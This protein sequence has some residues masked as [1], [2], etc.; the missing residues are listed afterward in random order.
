MSEFNTNR[1]TYEASCEIAASKGLLVVLPKPNEL[2]IDIDSDSAFATFEV[3]VERVR[4]FEPLS[5]TVK[6][7]K[8]G[9]PCRH[10]TVELERSVADDRER[11]LL[12]AVLGSDPFREL[13]SWASSKAGHTKPTMFFED[14]LSLLTNP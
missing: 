6:P 13:L 9:G 8:S 4:K 5:Y 7:S 12:Q 14:P 10:V 3:Q 1:F 2:L 11:I